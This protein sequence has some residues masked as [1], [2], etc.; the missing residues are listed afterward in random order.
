MLRALLLLGVAHA[1]APAPYETL[2]AA[3]VVDPV[4]GATTSVLEPG[5]GPTLVA[6]VP[7]LGEF[8]SCEF[9]E[10]LAA[11]RASSSV[12]TPSASSRSSPVA[13][14]SSLAVRATAAAR[15]S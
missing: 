11:A 1:L 6:V 14:S 12:V 9:C 13:S 2:R 15:A 7:Q 3:R 4:S 5:H 8:D 10:F